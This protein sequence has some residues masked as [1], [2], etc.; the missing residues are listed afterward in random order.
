MKSLFYTVLIGML[1]SSVAQ[2]GNNTGGFDGKTVRIQIGDRCLAVVE[3]STARFIECRPVSYF[4]P[5]V[6]WKVLQHGDYYQL[7]NTKNHRCAQQDSNVILAN[8]D[9][10]NSKQLWRFYYEEG[11]PANHY[12]VISKFSDDKH[13]GKW[14][15]MEHEGDFF[16]GGGALVRGCN[17]PKWTQFFDIFIMP[18]E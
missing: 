5:E 1:M 16:L 4:D 14:D 15:C 3:G 11:Y 17:K 10:N 18:K 7:I 9:T 2:A 8:C 13:N 6:N 12:K